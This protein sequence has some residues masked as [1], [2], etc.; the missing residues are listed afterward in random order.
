LQDALPDLGFR[1][2][3]TDRRLPQ[4]TSVWLPDGVD[5]GKTRAELRNRFGIEV[6]GGLGELAGKGWRIGLMGHSARERSV[7][8]L[9]GALRAL[10]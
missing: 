3:A 9:L 2:F 8:T 1:A 6:G 5:D 10:L 7:V 4:L